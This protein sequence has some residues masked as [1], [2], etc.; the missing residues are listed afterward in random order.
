MTKLH[1]SVTSNCNYFHAFHYKVIKFILSILD[2]YVYDEGKIM[3]VHTI[4]IY[5]YF[6]RISFFRDVTFQISNV[7]SKNFPYNGFGFRVLSLIMILWISLFFLACFTNIQELRIT[8]S[9]GLCSPLWN[10][11]TL[12]TQPDCENHITTCVLCDSQ[13]SGEGGAGS[14]MAVPWAPSLYKMQTSFRVLPSAT[15]TEALSK[16]NKQIYSL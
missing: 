2:A 13:R 3:V 15:N 14:Y 1:I 10:V 12:F 5:S 6:Q 9:R 11:A 16:S 7:V 8:E 4:Y